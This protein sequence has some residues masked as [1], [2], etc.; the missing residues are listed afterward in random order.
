MSDTHVVSLSCKQL[1]V[2]DGVVRRILVPVM[3]DLFRLQVTA[4][5]LFHHQSVFEDV[6]STAGTCVRR[7]WMTRRSDDQNVPVLPDLATALPA[8]R[9]IQSFTEHRIVWTN[10]PN[11][12]HRVVLARKVPLVRRVLVGEIAC[13]AS[14]ALGTKSSLL[15]GIFARPHIERR[16]ALRA[17]PS[18]AV[19]L[20][21]ASALA[22]AIAWFD[23]WVGLIHVAAVGT[24]S[25]N[26]RSISFALSLQHYTLR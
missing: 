11:S 2:L 20:G 18:L 7:V 10:A 1:K 22:T 21:S 9:L 19:P 26:H 13:R 8:R 4:K 12:K 24:G 3:D 16:S 23:R 17:I 6:G 15:A 5:V 14:A 25:L